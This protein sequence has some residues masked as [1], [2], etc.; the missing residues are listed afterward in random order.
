MT[1]D[2]AVEVHVGGTWVDV[3]D[4][5]VYQRDGIGVEVIRGYRGVSRS[6]VSS[7]IRFEL[8]NDNGDWSPYNPVSPHHGQLN[9]R[10]PVRVAIREVVTDAFGEAVVDG[11]GS[12]DT[13]EAW[14]LSG[15][16][17]T[18]AFSNWQKAGGVGTVTVPVENAVRLCRLPVDMR[19]FEVV[20]DVSTNVTT[21]TGAPVEV[22][23][24]WRLGGAAHYATSVEIQT[25]R[26]VEVYGRFPDN[27]VSTPVVIPG[28][29]NSAGVAMRVRASIEGRTLRARVWPAGGDEPAEWHMVESSSQPVDTADPA[30]AFRLGSIVASGNTNG[31]VTFTY[32]NLEIRY[33]QAA[34]IIPSWPEAWDSTG[35]DG[36]VQI[37]AAGVLYRLGNERAPIRSSLYRG[38]MATTDS[39]LEYWPA[40][41]TSGATSLASAVGG[42]PMGFTAWV[43]GDESRLAAHDGF[44]CSAP[45]PTL[46]NVEWRGIIRAYQNTGVIHL[47]SLLYFPGTTEESATGQAIAQMWFTGGSVRNYDLQIVDNGFGQADFRLRLYDAAGTQ[48]HDSGLLGLETGGVDGVRFHVTCTQNGAS[49]D[50]LVATAVAHASGSYTYASTPGTFVGTMGV[51]ERILIN[52]GGGYVDT[53]V[54]HIAVS[55]AVVSVTDERA[56]LRAHYGEST[57]NRL[58]RL[59]EEEG[60]PFSFDRAPTTST[61]LGPQP[62]A[63]LSQVIER[64]VETDQGC[65]YEPKSDIGLE[66]RARGSLD[67]QAPRAILDYSAGQLQPRWGPTTDTQGL[68]NDVT[69]NNH[70]GSSARHVK[71]NGPKSVTDVGRYDEPVEVN[72]AGDDDLLDM[73][74]WRVHL[75]TV[76]EPRYPPVRTILS[77]AGTPVADLLAVNIGDRLQ[78]DNAQS[79]HQYNGISQL[80]WGYRA[81]M[82][83]VMHTRDFWVVPES[84][85]RVAVLDDDDARA[86][87]DGSEIAVAANDTAT[88]LLVRTRDMHWQSAPPWTT[89]PTQFPFDV[90]V[91]GERCTVSAITDTMTFVGVGAAAHAANAGVTPGMPVAWQAGDL[92]LLWGATRASAQGVPTP[93]TGYTELT[94][95]TGNAKLFARIA[96]AGDAAPTMGFSGAGGAGMSVSAQMS[97]F[98]S[99]GGFA[100]LSRIVINRRAQLNGS[101]QNIAYPYIHAALPGCLVLHLGWKQDDWTDATGVGTEIGE[102]TTTLGDDQGMWWGYDIFTTPA[103]ELGADIVVT[104]GVAAASRGIVLVIHPDVQ[105]FTV[106]RSVN[107]VVKPQA[108]GNEVELWHR[109]TIG[110]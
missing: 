67:N 19:D 108:A 33:P 3:V 97:A 26:T 87:T 110:L 102:F 11:W 70:L 88:T 51:A 5:P 23:C 15:S 96:E 41:D 12:T 106:T 103:D 8:A 104:G 58:A 37:D 76:D 55:N 64:A 22:L 78:I 90:R 18:V 38:I 65:V 40:E 80:V 20:F 4:E 82:R 6:L 75:G 44:V 94:S 63:P 36:S 85:Y 27:S 16:G 107:G 2:L 43:A 17:G 39:L 93:P 92:L 7:S 24:E 72:A 25:D 28:L 42:T 74:A 29:L 30:G 60:I 89:D 46:G 91:A 52:P 84:P 57:I 83:K 81:T 86:D 49:V 53:A 10:T 32:D 69:V 99:A 35:R 1:T 68:V 31:S 14:E 71:E 100:D 48:L 73:A 95:G 50:Y 101:L 56:Q 77:K 109:P 47:R 98:R 61:L 13:G 66:Y 62:Q 105:A 34:G 45:I 79:I 9:Q 59:C 21:P 54:G